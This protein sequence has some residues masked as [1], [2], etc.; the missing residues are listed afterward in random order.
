MWTVLIW[1]Y[2]VNTV[3]HNEPSVS[4]LDKLGS[5]E[6]VTELLYYF[7][8]SKLNLFNTVPPPP[9][10]LRYPAVFIYVITIPQR[11]SFRHHLIFLIIKHDSLLAVRFD[12]LKYLFYTLQPQA[13]GYVL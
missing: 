2:L 6:L 3:G 13:V 9:P 8:L 7:G 12:K 4:I 10:H 11:R 1:H 5:M